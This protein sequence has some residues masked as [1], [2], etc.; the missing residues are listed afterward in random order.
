M[1]LVTTFKLMGIDIFC[2]NKKYLVFN[3]IQRNLKVKYRRSILGVFWTLLAPLSL[4]SI[5]FFVFQ[6]VLRVSTPHY[7]ASI[8]CSILL[9]NFFAQSVA[10]GM[11]SL[12]T[13]SG[14]ITKIPVPLQVFP[15]VGVLTNVVTLLI[16]FPLMIC[17]SVVSE[18]SLGTSLFAVPII[19]LSV[20]I[21]AYAVALSMAIAYVYLHDLKHLSSLILQFWFY[22]TPVLYESALVPTSFR[23]LLYLNPVGGPFIGMKDIFVRGEWPSIEVFALTVMWPVVLLLVSI[24]YFKVKAPQAPELL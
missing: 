15:Y 3:M 6:L 18:V 16:S 9:W 19:F 5:Y 22:A 2:L 21:S 7:L 20:A 23:W 24:L 14:L 17:V 12:L 4:C 11:E 10:E 1:S 13:N 8:V